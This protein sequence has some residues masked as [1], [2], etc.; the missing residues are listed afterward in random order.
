MC[1]AEYERD[2]YHTMVN[3]VLGHPYL[4]LV[5][6]FKLFKFWTFQLIYLYD[7]SV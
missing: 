7:F 2:F 1:T 4:V 5:S 6:P 3:T